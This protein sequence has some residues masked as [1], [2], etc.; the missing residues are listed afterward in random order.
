MF[1]CICENCNQE[2][3]YKYKGKKDRRF[4]SLQ[5][6][7][8]WMRKNEQGEKS[9]GWRGVSKKQVCPVCGATYMTKGKAKQTFCSRDC[10]ARHKSAEMSK[11]EYE[12]YKRHGQA[13]TR[14]YRIWAG[15]KFRATNLQTRDAHNYIGRGIALCDR[16]LDFENFY[17]DMGDAPEGMSLDRIDNNGNYGPE[18]CRWTTQEE[19]S[20]NKRNNIIISFNGQKNTLA[21]WARN[22]GIKYE[23]LLN[24]YNRKWEINRMFTTPARCYGANHEK[25]A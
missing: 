24:R 9:H 12:H 2:F 22:L 20:N 13:T 15:M 5:C 19:Q 17:K 11:L 1:K 4:C 3:T 21:N 18:N 6:Y 10:Y 25:R 7:G 23:V 14:T 8:N 16:W